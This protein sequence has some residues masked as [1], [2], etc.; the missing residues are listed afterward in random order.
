[1]KLPGSFDKYYA[2]WQAK[3]I[4]GTEF[5]K[6]LGVSRPALYQYIRES[7]TGKVMPERR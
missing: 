4:T 1:M 6:L 5:A 7:E 3:E 2:M